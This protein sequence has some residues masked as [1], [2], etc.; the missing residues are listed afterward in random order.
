MSAQASRAGHRLLFKWVVLERLPEQLQ[1]RN[2][3]VSR[4]HVS[5]SPSSLFC[6]AV[7]WVCFYT[8]ECTRTFCLFK[9]RYFDPPLCWQLPLHPP[10]GKATPRI[11]LDFCKVGPL[12]KLAPLAPGSPG[13]WAEPSPASPALNVAERAFW[14][15]PA[16][17]C[18]KLSLPYRCSALQTPFLRVPTFVSTQS[19]LLP[20]RHTSSRFCLPFFVRRCL[21]VPSPTEPRL[22][23]D[24]TLSGVMT[25]II[26][27][28]IKSCYSELCDEVW[29]AE[30]IVDARAVT[31]PFNSPR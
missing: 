26:S 12:F 31:Q 4:H 16:S 5:P 30:K 27:A 6:C 14:L 23:R 8:R 1:E 13:N 11:N 22:A 24:C 28:L 29:G 17:F 2:H 21:R 25:V 18:W 19:A 3:P 15:P 7:V 9:N 10:P 20:P